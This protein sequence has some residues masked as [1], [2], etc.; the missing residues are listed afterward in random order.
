MMNEMFK[1]DDYGRENYTECRV[2]A[3]GRKGSGN[4]EEKRLGRGKAV[5]TE[6]KGYLRDISKMTKEMYRPQT[7][8]LGYKSK[9]AFFSE[10]DY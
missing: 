7:V 3:G 8:N 4:R 9:L 6:R 5:G 2:R 10:M 1:R